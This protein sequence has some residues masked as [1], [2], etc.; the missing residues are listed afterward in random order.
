MLGF[1]LL[2]YGLQ[3]MSNGMAPLKDFP[4]VTE[5]FRSVKLTAV[6]HV[7]GLPV[8]DKRTEDAVS[9]IRNGDGEFDFVQSHQLVPLCDQAVIATEG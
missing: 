5:F 7:P 2:F 9:R 8:T 3:V 6:D 1:G 4:E